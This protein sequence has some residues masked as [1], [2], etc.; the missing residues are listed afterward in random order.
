MKLSVYEDRAKRIRQYLSERDLK[1]LVVFQR[2]NIQ[3]VSGM[4]A[5]ANPIERPSAAIIPLDGE[6]SLI[7]C[8]ISINNY[9][10]ENEKGDCWIKD[11][12][13]YLEH[14]RL[15]NRIET[16]VRWPEL[17]SSVLMEKGLM[18]GRIGE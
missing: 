13:F 6:P 17:V 16:V 12:K 11:A 10:I 3:Y 9:K 2:P 8:E 18:R 7:L 14:P 4:L 15:S 1:A 5:I